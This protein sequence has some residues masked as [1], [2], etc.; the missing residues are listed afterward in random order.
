MTSKTARKKKK[1]EEQETRL[2]RR[3]SQS[4][5]KSS[6]T[7]KSKKLERFSL[8]QNKYSVVPHTDT[9]ILK[10]V[11]S[12]E[13]ILIDNRKLLGFKRGD[14][15]LIHSTTV[16][17]RHQDSEKPLVLKKMECL[18]QSIYNLKIYEID[19][20]IRFSNHPN[21]V[22]LYSYWNEEP[23]NPFTFK[24]LFLLFEE[25]LVGD[26]ERCIVQNALKPSNKT[27]MKYMCDLCKGVTVLHQADTIH[28]GIRPSNLLI[29][30]LNDLCLGPIKKSELES[31]RKTR[32][33]LSK[34]CIERYMKHY[35]IFWAPEVILDQQITK[36]SDIWAIGVLLYL[37]VTGEYPFD[38]KNEEQVINNIINCNVNWRLLTSY[39]KI[40]KL[41][42]N[43][44]IPDMEKRLK[45]EKILQK[46]QEDF[47]IIIQRFWRGSVERIKFRAKCHA[48]VKI[49]ALVKGWFVRKRYR[50][51]RFQLRWQA[52]MIIQRRIRKF[53]RTKF[54]RT[55]RKLIMRLQANVLSRQTRRAFLKLKKDSITAQSYIILFNNILGLSEGFWFTPVLDA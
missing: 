38:L 15:N 27:I 46:C 10:T 35:F 20:H 44:F 30:E 34:F 22:T 33:L 11:R 19:Q 42:R 14:L 53:K 41:L 2:M 17:C 1:N 55:T 54:Y 51:R 48:L 29:N 18:D 40:T 24:T 9:T 16:R 32:H 49:Q 4:S 25:C 37:L 7:N 23:D 50:E 3:N 47:A 36:A 43:I 28:G 13:P 39:P 21:I 5:I 45:S 52:A 26:L 12:L 8:M 6:K 31:M